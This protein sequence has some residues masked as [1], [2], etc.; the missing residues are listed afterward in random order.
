MLNDPL[1][2]L[3][4]V[5]AFGLVLSIWLVGVLLWS[6]GKKKRIDQVADRMKLVQSAGARY[7]AVPDE[8]EGRV[9]RLWRDG[10]EATT[11]VPG[12]SSPQGIVYSLERYRIDAGLE[13]SLRALILGGIGLLAFAAAVA[14]LLTA[15]VMMGI[16]APVAVSV[17]CYIIIAQRVARRQAIFERQLV[18][19]LELAARS[20]RVGHPLVGSFRMIS[21]EIGAPVGL[22]FG[23]VCQQQELGI[24]LDEA[25]RGVAARTYSDDLK[26]FATSVV[27]QLRSGGNLADM[28]ERVAGVIRERNRLARRVRVLTAQTQMSKRILLALPF[29]VF[30][31]L[32]LINPDYMRPLY[33]TMSGQIIM[34][35]AAVGL[36]IGWMTM[37][38]ISKL[39]V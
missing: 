36:L 32:N 38:W 19:G 35:V 21:E 26:L 6:L 14:Y 16:A 29:F 7:S 22:L 1:S 12:R 2:I 17:L 18:D 30:V 27:I 37:N 39:E 4:A 33:S 5:A 10:Q 13:S 8:N 23:E 28:M 15:S 31:L 25:L 9:L 3:I 20:L 24:S 11:V 34:A